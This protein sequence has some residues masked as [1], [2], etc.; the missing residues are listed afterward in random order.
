[1]LA[2]ISIVSRLKKFLFL[3]FSGLVLAIFVM[4]LAFDLYVDYLSSV[5]KDLSRN[6]VMIHDTFSLK[7]NLVPLI[8]GNILEIK[9]FNS[10]GEIVFEHE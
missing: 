8:R 7:Q 4:F 9:V 1:M 3:Y 5:I 2:P 6:P 10:A